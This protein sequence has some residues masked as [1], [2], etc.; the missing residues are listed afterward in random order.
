MS[1]IYTVKII[2]VE[3]PLSWAA[4][5]IGL[6]FDALKIK[7]HNSLEDRRIFLGTAPSHGWIYEAEAEIFPKR[8]AKPLW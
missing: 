3:N 7:H 8:R 5:Q 4:N 1:T 6:I 2:H